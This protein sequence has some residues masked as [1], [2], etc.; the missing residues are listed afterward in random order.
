MKN[1]VRRKEKGGEK[2]KRGG[3]GGGEG[4]GKRKKEKTR[5]QKGE[6]GGGDL[7]SERVHAL[8]LELQLGVEVL[9]QEL[10]LSVKV[11][12]LMLE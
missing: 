9:V 7:L 6:W 1:R 5:R 11:T 3:G 10:G 12:V 4:G 8:Q 2:E